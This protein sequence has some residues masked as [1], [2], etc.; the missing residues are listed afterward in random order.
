MKILASIL[1]DSVE[2][3]PFHEL[4]LSRHT[5]LFLNCVSFLDFQILQIHGNHTM[6]TLFLITLSKLT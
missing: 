2:K 4:C 5:S 6:L 1:F 3:A